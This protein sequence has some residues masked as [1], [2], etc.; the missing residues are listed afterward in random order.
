MIVLFRQHSNAGDYRKMIL[1]RLKL[2]KIFCFFQHTLEIER[3]KNAIN[4]HMLPLII[5]LLLSMPAA[6]VLMFT[7]R[8]LSPIITWTLI[9]FFHI[10]LIDGKIEHWNF[11]IGGSCLSHNATRSTIII[12]HSIQSTIFVAN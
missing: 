8:W 6:I 2:C 9:V 10:G 7:M 11:F 1:N 12:H 3:L 5:I 4:R